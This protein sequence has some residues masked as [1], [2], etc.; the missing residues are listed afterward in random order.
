M[1]K[2]YRISPIFGILTDP[3]DIAVFDRQQAEKDMEKAYWEAQQQAEE[4]AYLRAIEEEMYNLQWG[5][6]WMGLME[7]NEMITNY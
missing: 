2:D 6:Y 1:S 7:E 4:E 5:E 3:E